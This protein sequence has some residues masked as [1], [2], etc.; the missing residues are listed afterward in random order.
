MHATMSASPACMARAARRSAITPQ[1]PPIGNHSRYR[2]DRPT[3]WVNATAVSGCNVKLDKHNPSMADF[4]MPAAWSKRRSAS[5]EEPSSAMVR[6]ADIR[7]RHR[8]AEGDTVV[9]ACGHCLQEQLDRRQ[10][11]VAVQQVHALQ[12]DKQR[13]ILPHQMMPTPRRSASAS[14]RHV[15]RHSKNAV[16]VTQHSP[17][18]LSISGACSTCWLQLSGCCEGGRRRRRSMRRRSS[19]LSS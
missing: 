6:A 2:G 10:G 3:C 17:S 9:G 5:R 18:W 12:P 15:P 4:G 11:C 8:A 14:H 16:R 19:S 1:A 7:F 13:A